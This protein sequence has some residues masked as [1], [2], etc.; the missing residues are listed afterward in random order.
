MA[1]GTPSRLATAT[2]R[3]WSM[4]AGL[5]HP[6]EATPALRLVRFGPLLEAPDLHQPCAGLTPL[7]EDSW[8]MPLSRSG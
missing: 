8:L 7:D 5:R 4:P 3:R 1:A 6:Q 2:E